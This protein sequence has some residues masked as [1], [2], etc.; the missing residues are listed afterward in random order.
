[1]VAGRI[2]ERGHQ[3][4][5]VVCGGGDRVRTGGRAADSPRSFGGIE[6]AGATAR[7]GTC[8]APCPNP[9]PA[10][11]APSPAACAPLVPTT[12]TP[13]GEPSP[14]S[15]SSSPTH[16]RKMRRWVHRSWI[17]HEWDRGWR[18][19]TQ[20]GSRMAGARRVLCERAGDRDEGAEQ[21]PQRAVA[22]AISIL[23]NERGL[24]AA[25]PPRPDPPPPAWAAHHGAAVR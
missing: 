25:K 15:P 22:P 14:S 9:I 7:C 4:S 8:S 18:R 13:A 12:I 3:R 24:S 2:H 19:G 6:I 1:M 17:L 10:S 21:V 11:R 23:P 16:T 20:V 5:R